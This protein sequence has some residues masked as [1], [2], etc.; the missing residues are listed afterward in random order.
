MA[1]TNGRRKAGHILGGVLAAAH[2]AAIGVPAEEGEPGPPL[3]VLMVGAVVGLVI[4]ALLVRSWRADSRG[5]RRVAAVLL[6]LAALGA[7]PGLLVAGVPVALQIG[8]GLLVLLTI[9]AVVLLF[10]PQRAAADP[11]HAL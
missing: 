7:L 2:I 10:S 6:L 11:V 8:A 1:S 5:A 4:L 9:A 3:A